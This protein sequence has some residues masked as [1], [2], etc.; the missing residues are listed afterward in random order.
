MNSMLANSYYCKSC[1]V[2]KTKED[3]YKTY[4]A[5]CKECRKEQK[6]NQYHDINKRKISREN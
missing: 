5:A 1:K 6:R 4:K 3:F 2:Q